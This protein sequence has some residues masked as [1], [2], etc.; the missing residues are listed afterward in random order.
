MVDMPRMPVVTIDYYAIN[1]DDRIVQTSDFNHTSVAR[2]FADNGQR[3]IV[4][5]KYFA[6]AV[7]THTRGVDIV[8]TYGLVVGRSGILRLTAGFNATRTKVTHVA[9]A[10]APVARFQSSLFDRFERGKMELGQPHHT[11]TSTVN[12]SLKRLWG[13]SSQSEISVRPPCSMAE[14]LSWIRP[15]VQNGSPMPVSH[16]A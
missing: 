5:A 14:I 7:D 9:S 4:S 2:I 8:S 12:Y 11:F 15:C 3:G 6:N 1:V 10:P 13:E 16:I